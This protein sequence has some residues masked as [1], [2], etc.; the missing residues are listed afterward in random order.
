MLLFTVNAYA[1]GGCGLGSARKIMGGLSRGVPTAV[2]NMVYRRPSPPALPPSP[3]TGTPYNAF[4]GSLHKP[5]L[6][7]CAV[8]LASCEHWY[9]AVHT[10]DVVY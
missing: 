8:A 9:Y 3:N 2:V 7:C 5:S 4:R 1:D 6:N 10:A